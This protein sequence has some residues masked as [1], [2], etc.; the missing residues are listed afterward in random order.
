MISLLLLIVLHMTFKGGLVTNNY[1]IHYTQL[2]VKVGI[3]FQIKSQGLF[4]ADPCMSTS[5]NLCKCTYKF[6]RLFEFDVCYLSIH[7]YNYY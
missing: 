2:C 5:V 3:K 7:S 1:V 4:P 6:R